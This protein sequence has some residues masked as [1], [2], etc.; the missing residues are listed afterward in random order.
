M[1]SVRAPKLFDELAVAHGDGSFARRLKSLGGVDLLIFD[2]R[3]PERLGAQAG[4]DLL[5][6]LEERYGRRSTLLT[7]QVPVA[8]WHAPVGNATYVDAILDRLVH[9]AHRLDL[10][11]ESLRQSKSPKP[12]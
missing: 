7:S 12:A 4:H 8:D 5:E 9:N 11:G 10:T 6:A 1:L 3:G 2:D